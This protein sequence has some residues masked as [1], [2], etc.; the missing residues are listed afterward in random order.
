LEAAGPGKTLPSKEELLAFQARW[1]RPAGISAI[2]GAVIVAISLPIQ[3]SVSGDSDAERL[4]KIHDNSTGLIVGQGILIGIG[5]LLFI[6]L[7]YVLIRSVLGR[8]ERVRRGMISLAF[9]GPIIFSVSGLL[10][11][12]G[13]DDAASKFV[14]QAP[15][16]ERQAREQAVT[17]QST[18]AKGGVKTTTSG[19][20]TS[21]TTTGTTTTAPSTPDQAV[22]KA[23]DDL[24]NKVIDDANLLKIGSLLRF[25]GLISLVFA[26]IYIPLW[27][28]RTGLLTRFWAMLGLALGVSL[29][30]IPVGIFGLVLWFA[31]IGLMLAGWWPRPLPP[32]WEAGEAIPWP[33]RQDIGPPPEERGGPA[34]VEGS[35]REVSEQPLA[36]NGGGEESGQPRQT[37]GQRR[38]KRKRRK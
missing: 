21:G 33:S 22:S 29:V 8:T 18:A 1:M 36:E 32:A 5:V 24:A 12:L 31:V 34:T 30:L 27:S 35:G 15:A 23:R 4:T 37:E 7:L 9:I 16:K 25:A 28:M 20:T 19:T 6:P 3:P 13:L 26:L 17:S 10:V 38:K 11:A 2:L 14:E